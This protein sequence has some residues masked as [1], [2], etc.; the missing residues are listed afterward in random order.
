MQVGVAVEPIDDEVDEVLE[1]RLLGGAVVRPE[2]LEERRTVD[3]LGDAE[4]VLET[5][6]R[7]DAFVQSLDRGLLVIRALSLPRSRS[8]SASPVSSS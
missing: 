1:R 4:Q 2:P 5:A 8:L 6:T 7:D 3:D